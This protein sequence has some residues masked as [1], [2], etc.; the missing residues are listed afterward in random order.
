MAQHVS[1]LALLSLS[2]GYYYNTACVEGQKRR[3]PHQRPFV[4][5]RS[6][7]VGSQ[8]NSAIWTGDVFANWDHLSIVVPMLLGMSMGGIP[9]T[10]SDVPG[11]FKDP[12]EVV[13]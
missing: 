8:R 10:G 6:F 7:F 12:T 3:S 2:Y 9:F 13:T 1:F 4:L 5:S 11:F